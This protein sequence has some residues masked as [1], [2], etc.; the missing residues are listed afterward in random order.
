MYNRR[1]E[2]LDRHLNK[3]VD[4]TFTDG[5]EETGVLEYGRPIAPELPP[6][7]KYSLYV[8]GKG[9]TRFYKSAVKKIKEH[10]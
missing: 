6:R 5:D 4:I 2:Q 7:Q 9:Y 1:S 8:F 10:K 3:L